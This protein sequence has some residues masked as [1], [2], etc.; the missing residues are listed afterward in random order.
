MFEAEA[1]SKVPILPLLDSQSLDL[2]C[3][4]YQPAEGLDCKVV[5]PLQTEHADHLNFF[6]LA[7]VDRPAEQVHGLCQAF[8]GIVLVGHLVQVP[9]VD[10]ALRGAEEAAH[11]HEFSKS[12]GTFKLL[13][14]LVIRWNEIVL[15]RCGAIVLRE[16]SEAEG[17][18]G[19][20]DTLF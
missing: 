6:D 16:C 10:E 7:L 3:V 4:K 2:H 5:V 20:Q 9:F 12:E 13:S 11:Q 15:A 19:S 17:T 18:Q 14:D 8:S 1:L